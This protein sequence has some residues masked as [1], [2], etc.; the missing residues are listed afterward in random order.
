MKKTCEMMTTHIPERLCELLL[1][2]Y[3]QFPSGGF[4]H[5]VTDD[6]NWETRH[7]VWCLLHWKD[8]C[9]SG[10]ELSWLIDH[11]FEISEMCTLLLDLSEKQRYSIWKAVEDYQ[12]KVNYP[13]RIEK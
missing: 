3:D 10:E 7:I 4:L 6:G 1:L 2:F 12:N 9:D 5:V 11:E 8:Y 13:K